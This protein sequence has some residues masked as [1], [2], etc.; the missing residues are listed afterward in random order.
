LIEVG[1]VWPL[2]GQKSSAG[3]PALKGSPFEINNISDRYRR[4]VLLQKEGK[5]EDAAREFECI[6]N[7]TDME[8]DVHFAYGRLLQ[9]KEMRQQALSHFLRALEL[10]PKDSP[11]QKKVQ[12]ALDSLQTKER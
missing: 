3:A 6:L 5:F 4:A 10:Y 12:Q 8:P 2:I 11:W 1:C 9:K 7:I